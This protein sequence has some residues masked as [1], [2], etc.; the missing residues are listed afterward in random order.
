MDGRGW[1]AKMKAFHVVDL[2]KDKDGPCGLK[3]TFVQGF[4]DP[5]P[6]LEEAVR[7][8]LCLWRRWLGRSCEYQ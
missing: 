5:I 7:R 6:F 2:V 8:G 3:V 1:E 4:A